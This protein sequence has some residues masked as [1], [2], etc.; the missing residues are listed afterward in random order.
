MQLLL[1]T[2]PSRQLYQ[3]RSLDS[4]TYT[5]QKKENNEGILKHLLFQTLFGSFFADGT[6]GWFQKKHTKLQGLH[7]SNIP[8]CMP[9]GKTPHNRWKWGLGKLQVPFCTTIELTHILNR[10]ESS[11]EWIYFWNHLMRYMMCI[12]QI[13]SLGLIL[14]SPTEDVCWFLIENDPCFC[15]FA[16]DQWLLL[17]HDF[18]KSLSHNG[19]PGKV[20]DKKQQQR[21]RASSNCCCVSS[22]RRHF[23]FW[24]IWESG[25]PIPFQWL[26]V[27]SSKPNQNDPHLPLIQWQLDHLSKCGCKE[28]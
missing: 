24:K 27:T 12:L 10:L 15:K 5:S 22:E 2:L 6:V 9:L 1:S 7:L 25:L 20:V 18:W 26:H 28:C 4:F 3:K 14:V 8:Q 11:W 19:W 21:N 16:F 13:Q 23:P 17:L